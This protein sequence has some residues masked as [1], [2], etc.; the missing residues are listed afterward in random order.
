[1]AEN[2][3]E[4]IYCIE[5]I[6]EVY[7]PECDEGSRYHRQTLA[8]LAKYGLKYNEDLGTVEDVI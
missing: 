2:A 8:A 4:L 1:M 5:E 3:Q 6:L 7:L